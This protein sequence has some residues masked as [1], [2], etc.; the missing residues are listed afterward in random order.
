MDWS[1]VDYCDVFISCL[2]SHYDGTHSLQ[3]IH[4]WTS[5]LM[6]HFSKSVLIKTQAHLHLRWP[7]CEYFQNIWVNYSYWFIFIARNFFVY[8]FFQG[9]K[10]KQVYNAKSERFDNIFIFI[11]NDKCKCM[12][13][14]RKWFRRWRSRTR[15]WCERVELL[16]ALLLGGRAAEWCVW[17][18]NNISCAGVNVIFI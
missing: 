8:I 10:S 6:I 11:K 3:M 2:D 15:I 1:G 4:W 17:T 13:V 5:D 12:T 9:L 7:E 18:C 14:H 16:N